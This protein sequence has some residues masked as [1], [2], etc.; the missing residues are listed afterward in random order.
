MNLSQA[1]SCSSSINASAT[2]DLA[3]S[4]CD[5][6][7]EAGTKHND[8]HMTNNSSINCVSAFS[9]ESSAQRST[10]YKPTNEALATEKQYHKEPYHK[11][12]SHSSSIECESFTIKL[13]DADSSAVP[14]QKQR[15]FAKT[16][17]EKAEKHIYSHPAMIAALI[18]L[19]SD[20]D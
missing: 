15:L 5:I 3:L 1:E 16:R 10:A 20:D 8:F 17:K 6:F 18:E 4:L 19:D 14:T 11:E 9:S 13:N 2:V 7:K 12:P